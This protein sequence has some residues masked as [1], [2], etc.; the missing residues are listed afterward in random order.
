MNLGPDF[1][2]TATPVDRADH[3]SQAQLER[4]AKGLLV[5]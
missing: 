5:E 3:G 4:R 1:D 2:R